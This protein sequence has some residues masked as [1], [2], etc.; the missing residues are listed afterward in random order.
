MYKKI[1]LYTLLLIS[2]NSNISFANTYTLEDIL[3][4][5]EIT[6]VEFPKHHFDISSCKNIQFLGSVTWSNA[7]GKLF[8]FKNDSTLTS[9]I[10]EY[11]AEPIELSYQINNSN[12]RVWLN[13]NDPNASFSF[14][15][16]IN[17]N[18]MT[19]VID[20]AIKVQLIRKN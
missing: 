18:K 12:C 17:N 10:V 3:G 2:Q 1:L 20:Q 4:K 15:I 5:W 8:S 16:E 11:N 13:E 19:W 9:N 7:E 14:I 6:K